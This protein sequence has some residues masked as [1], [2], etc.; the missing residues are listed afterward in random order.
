MNVDIESESRATIDYLAG[1]FSS[2][3]DDLSE[4]EVIP[5]HPEPTD[6][7]QEKMWCVC[8]RSE[9]GEMIACDND[10]CAVEWFHFQCVNI[11]RAPRGKWFCPTC[12]GGSSKRK[13]NFEESHANDKKR[14]IAKTNCPECG[15]LLATSYLKMHMK[16][17]CA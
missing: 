10:N 13:L 12:S 3:S 8:N 7:E 2:D 5:E 11:K 17:F 15:K 14:K 1:F 6:A 16:K 4:E 9:S